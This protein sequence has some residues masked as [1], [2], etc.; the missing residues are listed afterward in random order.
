MSRPVTAAFVG[1][2]ALGFS[3]YGAQAPRDG[4]VIDVGASTRVAE[5][6]SLYFR[7]DGDFA[8]GNVN[9]ALNAGLRFVW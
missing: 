3:T 8:G 5:R 2:P 9:H 7:Y 6:T 4:M 1:A